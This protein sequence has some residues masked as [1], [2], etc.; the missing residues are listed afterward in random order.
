[1]RERV[2]GHRSASYLAQEILT[3]SDKVIDNYGDCVTDEQFSRRPYRKK[4]SMET[5]S[6]LK[7][8]RATPWLT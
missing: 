7:N 2:L 3:H 5:A 8:L 4:L 1:M 6:R